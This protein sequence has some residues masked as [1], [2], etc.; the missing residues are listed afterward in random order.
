MHSSAAELLENQI[1]VIY[2]LKNNKNNLLCPLLTGVRSF[3]EKQKLCVEHVISSV[4]R[5]ESE[6][7]ITTRE[8]H[9]IIKTLETHF[10]RNQVSSESFSR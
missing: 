1:K 6:L 10:Y 2:L 3:I 7:I 5:S 9:F 4:L 8:L